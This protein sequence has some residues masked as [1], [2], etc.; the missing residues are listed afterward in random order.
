MV[1]LAGTAVASTSAYAMHTTANR[2]A[3]LL[4][5]LLTGLV[6]SGA[7]AAAKPTRGGAQPVRS[8]KAGTHAGDRGGRVGPGRLGTIFQRSAVRLTRGAKTEGFDLRIPTFNTSKRVALLAEIRARLSGTPG[9]NLAARKLAAER[10]ALVQLYGSGRADRIARLE[11][12]I[13]SLERQADGAGESEKERLGDQRDEAKAELDGVVQSKQR[14]IEAGRE[15]ARS[16]SRAR[17]KHGVLWRVNR[18]ARAEVKQAEAALAALAPSGMSAT[19]YDGAR[20]FP[21]DLT[22]KG[23]TRRVLK[24]LRGNRYGRYFSRSETA[25]EAAAK[26]VEQEIELIERLQG[27]DLGEALPLRRQLTALTR[28]RTRILLAWAA[29]QRLGSIRNTPRTVRTIFRKLTGI[30][31]PEGSSSARPVDLPRERAGTPDWALDPIDSPDWTSRDLTRMSLADLYDGIHFR[32]ED[33]EVPDLSTGIIRWDSDRG[34]GTYG[35]DGMTRSSKGV[36]AGTDVKVKFSKEA[37]GSSA[38]IRASIGHALGYNT[39]PARFAARAR[40]DAATFLNA[41]ADANY[42]PFLIREGSRAHRL[43]QRVRPGFRPGQQLRIMG[44]KQWDR[45]IRV[46]IQ[47]GGQA[48]ILTGAEA[49]ARLKRA[50]GGMA[51]VGD[52]VANLAINWIEASGVELQYEGDALGDWKTLGPQHLDAFKD[53]RVVRAKALWD[54]DATGGTDIRTNNN[55]EEVRVLEGKGGAKDT[56]EVRMVTSDTGFGLGGA[57]P[58]RFGWMVPKGKRGRLHTDKNMYQYDVLDSLD[59]DSAIWATRDLLA[60]SPAQMFVMHFRDMGSFTDAAITSLA[61][62]SRVQSIER[63]LDLMG[64]LEAHYGKGNAVDRFGRT[65]QLRSEKAWDEIRSS[66]PRMKVG[67]L[68]ELIGVPIRTRNSGT[69]IQIHLGDR[70]SDWKPTGRMPTVAPPRVTLSSASSRPAAASR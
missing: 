68:A 41:F 52:P 69:E 30:G 1:I 19:E 7:T 58:T 35:P 55:R 20:R 6:L 65:I 18:A 64:A 67:D 62:T 48:R 42:Q 51:G 8:G 70:W 56:V 11:D 44:S 23:A 17:A 14:E 45:V 61:V 33:V 57:D 25:L 12:Q 22:G 34:H 27:A 21:R 49:R 59:R 2:R 37:R 39:T 66:I 28:T 54:H 26:V 13:E 10:E 4:T 50:L 46:E 5:A 47:E 31:R 9:R 53:H 43:L 3:A 36:L 38:S 32:T 40:M 29:N 63:N 24:Q 60:I 16:R 15:V